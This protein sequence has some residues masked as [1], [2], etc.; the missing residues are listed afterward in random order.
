MRFLKNWRYTNDLALIDAALLVAL[1]PVILVVKLPMQLFVLVAVGFI[2]Q[3]RRSW[4][5]VLL[6]LGAVAVGVSFFALFASTDLSRFRIF[7]EFIISLLLV[8]VAVQ[9]LQERLNFYLLISPFLLM[10]LGLFYY[11]SIS[12]LFFTILQLFIFTVLLLHSRM[13]QGLLDAVRMGVIVFFISAPVIVVLFLFFPRISFDTKD[14]GFKGRQLGAA[15]HDGQM[16]VDDRALKVLSKEVVMEVEFPSGFPSSQLYFRGSVLYENEGNS[17]VETDNPPNAR[18]LA[19][20]EEFITYNVTLYPHYKT[21]LYALDYPV[22]LPKKAKLE[23]G[24]VLKAQ[25]PI[26]QTK[27]YEMRSAQNYRSLQN[28]IDPQ[29]LHYDADKNPQTR[30]A[31]K[32]L[33]G[34]DEP[35]KRLEA[36]KDLFRKQKLRYSLEPPAYDLQNYVDAFLFDQRVGY[37]VHFASAFAVSARMAG[38]PARVVTGYK[39][40]MQNRV[41]NYIVIRREDAHAWTEIYLPKQGWV[42]VEAT[43]LTAGGQSGEEGALEAVDRVK[44]A[45]DPWELRLLYLKYRIQSWVLHY[46]YLKQQDFF[47]KLL[48]DRQFLTLF[49]L[50]VLFLAVLGVSIF[51]LLRKTRCKDPAVCLMQKLL[52]HL[53]KR[54]VV[55]DRSRSLHGFLSAQRD[56]G[57]EQIDRLYHR[58]EFAPDA[59]KKE[60]KTLK[61]LIE[62]YIKEQ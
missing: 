3:K 49:V 32:K 39:A 41:E 57:L 46:N 2:W 19:Q 7:V 22:S 5:Y 6:F 51:A 29:A 59:H 33:R 30:K 36:L 58:I 40:N 24:Y 44:T 10:S 56:P 16:Y 9:R 47:T 26:F 43:A 13:R 20:K 31:A 50:S 15:G 21:Y 45:P 1:A 62:R 48:R 34:I 60:L 28:S 11:E 25:K 61:R 38:L 4:Q 23:R 27:R 55:K 18:P 14:F 53:Q 52:A 42:R 37:C 12:A 17:W 54:G 8:A 35:A